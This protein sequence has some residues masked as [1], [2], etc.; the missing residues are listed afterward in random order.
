[1][2]SALVLP[3][4]EGF[5]ILLV[6]LGG[7]MMKSGLCLARFVATPWLQVHG[8]EY[9]LKGQDREDGQEWFVAIVSSAS[10]Q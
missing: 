6:R 4:G 8:K 5:A 7:H 9:T 2:L 10:L 1:M 3:D